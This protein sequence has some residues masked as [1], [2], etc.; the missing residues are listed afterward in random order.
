M[1]ILFKRSCIFLLVLLAAG[2][3]H[4]LFAQNPA[5]KAIYPAG[6]ESNDRPYTPAVLAGDT[7]YVSGQGA[8]DAAGRMPDDFP[9]QVH[10][11]L[12]N[13]QN[14]LRGAGM[15][16]GNIVWL[17]VYLTDM[18]NLSAMNQ[19]YWNMIGANPP[20][21]T[22]LQV[23][24][25]PAG[26]KVEVN[27]IAVADTEQRRN[28]WPSGWKRGSHIDP[29]AILAGD[30]L[31]MS[32]QG[33]SNPE[34]GNRPS[35]FA[36]EVKQALDNVGEV[37]KAA[38]MSYKNVVWVN[39][40]ME[41]G[42]RQAYGAM[43]KVYASYF[44]FGNT[45][46]RGTINVVGLPDGSHV[47][48][49]CIAGADLAKRKA[50]KPRNMPP[51]PTASPGVLYGNTLYL[52]AKDGFIPGQGL[53]T[54][55][56]DSQLRQSMRNLL[57]GLEEADMDFSNVVWSTVYL[58]QMQDYGQMNGLYKS[59]FQGM[60]P[61]RTTLQQNFETGAPGAEQISFIAVAT[62]KSK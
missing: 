62:P 21:R 34:T 28:I 56:F 39:P 4:S 48:F 15:D 8:L 1:K 2:F 41:A 36:G 58:R 33:D 13:L 52:S 35:D 47:V 5:L 51:S 46:G 20:A 26:Q 17:N 57:D 14:V 50:V 22:I 59:F 12:Q 7:L 45:P 29:P 18:S 27:C 23:A 9:G 53:V 19:V 3:G 49:S 16:L 42:G 30:V 10:Q 11:A 37:L 40:Y 60:F 25:L 61:A 6:Y 38:N 44:E 32:A 55:E 54:S 31:Y 24:A 43:N